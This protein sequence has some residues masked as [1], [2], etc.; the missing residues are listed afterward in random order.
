MNS[1]LILTHLSLLSLPR[2]RAPNLGRLALL[3]RP[4]GLADS[5]CASDGLLAEIGAVVTVGSRLDD[6]GVGPVF[7][8]L[9]ALLHLFAPACIDE[10]GGRFARRWV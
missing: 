5:G 10:E 4:L 9:I 6:G 7:S 3:D 8:Q 2:L 1:F